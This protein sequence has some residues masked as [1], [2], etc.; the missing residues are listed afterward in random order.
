MAVDPR[1]ALERAM[2]DAVRD[3]GDRARF[4]EAFRRSVVFVACL[5]P[6]WNDDVEPVRWEAD[7]GR[8]I[9]VFTSAERAMEAF[10]SRYQ[11]TGLPGRT[12]LARVR[13]ECLVVDPGTS[14]AIVISP[15]EVAHLADSAD[16]QRSDVG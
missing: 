14:A 4:L 13:G 10:G 9:A 16:V 11:L 3:G 5:P 2:I 6:G 1:D 8:C 12:L 7:G 15:D